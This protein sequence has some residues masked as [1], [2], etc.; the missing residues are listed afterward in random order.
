M[1]CMQ[2]FGIW[3]GSGFRIVCSFTICLFVC[4]ANKNY[5]R[6]SHMLSHYL[7]HPFSHQTGEAV[8][9]SESTPRRSDSCHFE[10]VSCNFFTRENNILFCN[11]CW[12]F[13]ITFTVLFRAIVATSW[14]L[15]YM[16]LLLVHSLFLNGE[17]ET[18]VPQN[19]KST[20]YFCVCVPSFPFVH[21]FRC[22]LF[23]GNPLMFII[24]YFH[25]RI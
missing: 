21:L 6:L 19:V 2:R 7:T 23:F 14:S 8:L 22:V 24:N 16:L 10:V 20:T 4:L 13:F 9:A 15:F 1:R 25:T 17:T 11:L 3:F 5:D 18:V 12:L